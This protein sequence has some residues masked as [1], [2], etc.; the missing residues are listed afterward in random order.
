MYPNIAC[1]ALGVSNQQDLTN[2]SECDPF[3]NTALQRF[4]C[5]LYFFFGALL[6]PISVGKITGKHYT[7]NYSS[8]L[9]GRSN[10]GNCESA[11]TEEPS[12]S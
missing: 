6:A 3:L 8:K 5:D 12:M 4:T 10:N 2:D 9:N 7:K 11:E 1:S